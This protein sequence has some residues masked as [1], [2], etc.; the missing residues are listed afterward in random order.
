VNDVPLTRGNSVSLEAFAKLVLSEARLAWRSPRGL[1]FGVGL[2]LGMLVL[3]GELPHFKQHPANLGGLSRFDAEIPVLAAFVIAALALLV[4][5]GPL[6]SYRE[7]GILR[8]MSTTPVRPAWLLAAQLIV[9]LAQA[10]IALTVLFA[11]AVAAFGVAAPTDPGAL[12]LS[13]GLCACAL[14]GLGLFIAAVAPT[15]GSLMIF[16]A[17]SFFP[18]IFL[19]GLW[20]PIQEMPTALQHISNY[21]AL[22]AAVQAAQDATEGMFPPTR[23]LLVMA[24]WAIVFGL[25]AWRF[26]RWE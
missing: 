2:P 22:G 15:S 19:A 20:V 5:A 16:Q 14:F 13:L 6:T 11:V 1:A 7:R 12:V 4:L 26:F 18:L 10:L 8:R 24:G 21:T 3:F 17:A 25:A 9:N 23:P